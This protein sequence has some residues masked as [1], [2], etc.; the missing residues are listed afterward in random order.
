MENDTSVIIVAAGK[1]SRMGNIDKIKSSLGRST[2]ISM[3]MKAFE[4]A[5][6]VK[7]I[8]VVT[9][10]ESEDFIKAEAERENITKFAGCAAGGE[11][12]QESV[13]NGLKIIS[14][15]T[16]MIA[17]HDGARPL[18]KTKDIENAIKDARVFG[19]STLGVP[20]K[21]TIKV[22]ED[23]L[24]VDTPYRPSL[25]YT[26]TP[27]VFKRQ[28]YFD[29]V[30]FCYE[31][32]IDNLTDDCQ[33]VETIGRKVYMT[34]GDYKNIKITTPEDLKIAEVLLDE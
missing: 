6:S 9:R 14:K 29:A 16:S 23:D 3:S 30:T 25:F 13:S 1:S 11:T 4:K 2:V 12:R 33:L 15:E 5:E 20:A 28:I 19:A 24:I 7:E 10:P 34:K 32:G 21:D 31:H 26:Q 17:V 27:Q 18:V 8:I 22:V